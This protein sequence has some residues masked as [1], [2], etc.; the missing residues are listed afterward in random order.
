[1]RS[2][3]SR[4]FRPQLKILP[5]LAGARSPSPTLFLLIASLS[6]IIFGHPFY[7]GLRTSKLLTKDFP[8]LAISNNFAINF[9]LFINSVYS[10]SASKFCVQFENNSIKNDKFFSYAI[11]VISLSSA[12]AFW[13]EG[14]HLVMP[15]SHLYVKTIFCLSHWFDFALLWKFSIIIDESN[16][17][18]G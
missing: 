7:S 17:W 14:G 3:S 10:F 4:A 1:M 18:M 8:S 2:S 16:R 12:G 6:N 11:D 15:H 9:F 13:V 5:L